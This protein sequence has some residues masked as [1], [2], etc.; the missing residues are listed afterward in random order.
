MEKTIT[1]AKLK[2]GSS[3]KL[4]GKRKF[5]VINKIYPLG[6]GA[7]IF[8]EHRNKILVITEQCKQFILDKEQEV[9]ISNT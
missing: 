7:N 3:F 8:P 6:S 5:R 2:R 1:A 9:I 4:S